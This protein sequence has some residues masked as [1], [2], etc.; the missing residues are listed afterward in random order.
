MKR[1]AEFRLMRAIVPLAFLGILVLAVVASKTAPPLVDISDLG[2]HIDQRV[3]V[4]GSVYDIEHGDGDR[5]FKLSIHG[6]AFPL[7]VEAI[8][9]EVDHLD[10][11][12]GDT[13]KVTGVVKT[14]RERYQILFSDPK[15]V[16][17]MERGGSLISLETLKEAPQFYL[18]K[19]ITIEGYLEGGILTDGSVTIAVRG[20]QGLEGSF[21]LEGRLIYEDWGYHFR[22]ERWTSC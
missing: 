22:A 20:V 1:R 16:E 14:Y 7:A 15:E 2:R 6:E 3:S 17:I 5:P 8:S 10:V 21:V 9:W 12:M 4:V 18:D 11:F 19:V 13:I